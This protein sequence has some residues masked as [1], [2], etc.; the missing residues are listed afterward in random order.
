MLDLYIPNISCGFLE[1]KVIQVVPEVLPVRYLSLVEH[2]H[3]SLALDYLQTQRQG[4]P[5]AVSGLPLRHSHSVP[6]ALRR[7]RM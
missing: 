2:E 1:S 4:K 3:P 5:L 6:A 7:A